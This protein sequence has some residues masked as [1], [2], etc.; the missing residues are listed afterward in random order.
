MGVN[1]LEEDAHSSAGWDFQ[2]RPTPA[3]KDN[4]KTL[5]VFANALDGYS[6]HTEALTWPRG[7][8]PASQESQNLVNTGN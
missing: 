7:Y 1:P 4:R 3:Y 8:I 2:T 6:V 5:L